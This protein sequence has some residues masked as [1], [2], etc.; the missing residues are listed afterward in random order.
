MENLDTDFQYRLNLV[1]YNVEEVVTEGE[2]E[3]LLKESRAPRCYVG[4]EPSSRVHIGWLPWMLKLRDLQRAGFEVIVLE[5]TWHAWINDKGTPGELESYT[6]KVRSVL[7][8]L[9]VSP[10]YV[11]SEDLLS[12]PEYLRLLLRASKNMPVERIRRAV[13]VMRRR[14]SEIEQDFS[15]MLYPL[16]QA[17]DSVYLNIDVAV[18]GLEQKPAFLMGRDV[19]ARLNSRRLV[20]L[21]LP[22]IPGLRADVDETSMETTD[23]IELY[24]E[25]KMTSSRP[26]D[27]IFLEDTVEDIERKII[28][29]YCPPKITR[30]NPLVSILKHVV[31]PY[32]GK[33]EIETTRGSLTTSDPAEIDKIYRAGELTPDDIK[34]LCIEYITRIVQELRV[35]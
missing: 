9:G 32:Y 25:I 19:V 6:E 29:A 12:D 13:V 31:L 24:S 3:S 1:K 4:Y 2:L 30:F 21:G 27:A 10:R 8:K 7:A 11:R 14:A 16:M 35:C 28:G 33:I 20:I 17:V 18:G 26:D 23:L 15:K 22:V 5:A 34:K